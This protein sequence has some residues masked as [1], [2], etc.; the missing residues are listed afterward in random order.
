MGEIPEWQE[1]LRQT[2]HSIV[3]ARRIPCSRIPQPQ[4]VIFQILLHS[5]L[6]DKELDV[7]NKPILYL[8]SRSFLTK[9]SS[10]ADQAATGCCQ[11]LHN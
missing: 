4:S 6:G 9:L 1:L 8:E 3:L 2:K 5:P 7:N 10:S 11:R